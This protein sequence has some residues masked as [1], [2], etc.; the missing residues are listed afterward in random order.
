MRHLQIYNTQDYPV[1][2]GGKVFPPLTITE[3]DVTDWQYKEI[4]ACKYLEPRGNA[5]DT[6]QEP[7]RA[8][9]SEPFSCPYCDEYVGKSKRGLNMH[10]KQA[11]EDKFE[12][13]KNS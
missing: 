13:F 6:P 7:N 3:V 5:Q 4:A 2:R 11:H 1:G 12:E 9:N 10:V 8:Q